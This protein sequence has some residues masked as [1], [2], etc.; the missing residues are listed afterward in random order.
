MKRKNLVSKITDNPHSEKSY[1][2]QTIDHFYAYFL[3]V[4]L[5]HGQVHN[6]YHLSIY[7]YLSVFLSIS[8][9]ILFLY[10]LRE[11]HSIFSFD[12]CIQPCDNQP[13]NYSLFFVFCRRHN[14]RLLE[15]NAMFLMKKLKKKKM[16]RKERIHRDMI[17]TFF[18][19]PTLT[20]YNRVIN[21][22]FC[23]SICSKYLVIINYLLYYYYFRLQKK[24]IIQSQKKIDFD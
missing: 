18:S 17:K 16:N 1:K 12:I 11:T 6:A 4:R 3:N 15:L 22:Y 5:I 2:S 9:K 23:L 21:G 14:Q 8:N 19:N 20:K 13:N 24:R 10:L 7:I